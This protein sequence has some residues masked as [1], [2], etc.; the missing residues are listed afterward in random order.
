MFNFLVIV[1]IGVFGLLVMMSLIL[2]LGCVWKYLIIFFVL[3]FVL[4]VK[5]VIFFMVFWLRII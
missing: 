2:I 3:L 1:R 4:E 5:M